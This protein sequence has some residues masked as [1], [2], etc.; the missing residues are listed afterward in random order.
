VTLPNRKMSIMAYGA[1]GVGKTTQFR[2][3]AK[4]V[5]DTYGLR[6]RF[7]CTDGGSLW[8]CVQDYI[9]EGFVD[10]L[11]VPSNPQ[12]NPYAVMRKLGRGLWPK[13]SKINLPKE[14]KQGG[15][16]KFQTNTEW[17][18]FPT[19]GSVGLIGTDSL[20]GYSSSYMYDAAVKNIRRGS[21]AGGG[22]RDEEGEQ[23]GSNTQSHYGDAQNEIKNYINSIVALPCPFSYFTALEDGGTENTTGVKRPVYGPQIAGSAATGELP[24]LVTNCF[25]LVAEGIGAGRVVKAF[26]EEHED[27]TLPPKMKWKA[28]ASSILPEQRLEFVK[29]FPNGYLPLSLKDGIR[30]FLTVKDEMDAAMRNGAK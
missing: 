25:H 14:I 30:E 2:Y 29:R 26:Y 19:D 21:E 7:I 5:H 15:E 20:T 11:L 28:K 12:Y 1:S 8:E 4:Y 18:P 22:V 13:D 3:M 10:A 6:S 27:P 16:T 23:Y 9:D 24:K 17:L